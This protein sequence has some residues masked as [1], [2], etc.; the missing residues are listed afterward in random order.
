MFFERFAHDSERAA[1]TGGTGHRYEVKVICNAAALCNLW[2]PTC[3]TLTQRRNSHEVSN[4]RPNPGI[5]GSVT[6]RRARAL[7]TTRKL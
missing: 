3:R 2:N 5:V 4:R 7:K 1:H 6:R